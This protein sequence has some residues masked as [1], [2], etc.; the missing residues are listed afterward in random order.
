MVSECFSH[1]E[2]GTLKPFFF[3]G[4]NLIFGDPKNKK[5]NSAN[6][7]ILLY[8]SGLDDLAPYLKYLVKIKQD[9]EIILIPAQGGRLEG[10]RKII[11]GEK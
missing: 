6:I 9:A 10:V 8:A 2:N 5:E 11:E 4:E 3:D 7:G 1:T